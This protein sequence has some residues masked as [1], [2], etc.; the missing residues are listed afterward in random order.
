MRICHMYDSCFVRLASALYSVVLKDSGPYV[1]AF[2]KVS[3]TESFVSLY[4]SHLY[5]N[6][7][8]FGGKCC[9]GDK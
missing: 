4:V 2:G 5:V 9:K 1:P 8:S 6:I 3:T 7:W